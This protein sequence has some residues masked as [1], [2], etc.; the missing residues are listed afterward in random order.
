MVSEPDD[1]ITLGCKRLQ[2][3]EFWYR[4]LCTIYPYGLRVLGTNNQRL[5]W[6]VFNRFD[7]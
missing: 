7:H 4:E 1:G 2:R 6:N 5:L 3:E